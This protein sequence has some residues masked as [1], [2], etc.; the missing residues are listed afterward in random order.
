MKNLRDIVPLVEAA[1]HGLPKLPWNKDPKIGWHEDGDHLVMY[2]GTHESRVGAIAKEGLK[3][4]SHGP[5]KGWV[6][7]THDPHTAHGYASMTGGESAF[8]AAGNKAKTVPHHERATL[9][10]HIPRKWANEN[11]NHHL[12]GNTDDV[13]DNLKNKQKYEE[14]KAAGKPDHEYYQKTEL[15]FKDHIPPEFIK[16]YMK[17]YEKK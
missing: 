15:R 4:P 5:T 7:M 17:R 11:M 9:V 16:G 10:Y 8:R 1:D 13:V 6:S 3:A 12:R 2:H 14:H